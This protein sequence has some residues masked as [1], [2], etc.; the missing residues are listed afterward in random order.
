MKALQAAAKILKT[1]G[2]L[3]VLDLLQ[4]TFEEARE[5]YG[6]TWLGFTEIELVRMAREAGFT[7]LT[8]TIVDK[9]AEPPHFQTLLLT[10]RT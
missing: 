3:L 1:G 2:R 10:G 4:H 8:T 6:D 9:E 5:L 7:E